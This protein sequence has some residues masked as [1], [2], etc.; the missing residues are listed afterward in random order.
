MTLKRYKANGN[1]MNMSFAFANLT[2]I[3]FLEE[4]W[5]KTPL[6]FHT[7]PFE[8][9]LPKGRVLPYGC[10]PVLSLYCLLLRYYFLA[11]TMKKKTANGKQQ[12][13]HLGFY[14]CYFT[15]PQWLKSNLRVTVLLNWSCFLEVI[16]SWPCMNFFKKNSHCRVKENHGKIDIVFHS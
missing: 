6:F 2:V 5:K 9:S 11:G 16:G 14:N 10:F 8:N 3:P 7:R 1:R 4:T 13:Y 12:I 15:L